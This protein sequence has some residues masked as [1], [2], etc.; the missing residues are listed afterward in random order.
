MAWEY[1]N[2]GWAY[3]WRG[4]GGRHATHKVDFASL[5]KR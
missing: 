1:M 4:G 3:K 2:N 5:T